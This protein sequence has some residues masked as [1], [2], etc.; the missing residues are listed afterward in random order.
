MPNIARSPLSPYAKSF[1]NKETR[2]DNSIDE[3]EA[4]EL[5]KP[6][7][8]EYANQIEE[9]SFSGESWEEV[10]TAN[11]RGIILNPKIDL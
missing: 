11:V 6:I 10:K 9:G 1:L 2:D 4:D 8:M 3:N 7:L 5:L